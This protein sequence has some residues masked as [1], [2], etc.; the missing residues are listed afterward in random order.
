MEKPY[1][2]LPTTELRP[3]RPPAFHNDGDPFTEEEL[4]EAKFWKK[5]LKY[6]SEGI[7]KMQEDKNRR[8]AELLGLEVENYWWCEKCQEEISPDWVTNDEK[9]EGCGSPVIG[10]LY[11]DFAADP[12]L[13]L[14]GM[15]KR[16]NWI[17]F[18]VFSNRLNG[19]GGCCQKDEFT[20]TICECIPINYVLNMTGILRDQAIK[21]LEE[22]RRKENE[23]S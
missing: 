22:E 11:P 8:L 7:K 16:K 6:T 14:R 4:Q 5:L 2:G 17:Q 18:L 10:K 3:N 21:W 23:K 1:K 9:C 12:R 20:M 15:M 13:V 19:L